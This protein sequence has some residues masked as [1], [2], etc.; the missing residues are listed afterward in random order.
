MILAGYV[1]FCLQFSVTECRAGVWRKSI[2]SSFSHCYM[3]KCRNVLFHNMH[4]GLESFS[5]FIRVWGKNVPCVLKKSA[6]A[7]YHYGFEC[8]RKVSLCL[9]WRRMHILL[10]AVLKWSLLWYRLFPIALRSWT[11]VNVLTTINA[12]RQL[13]EWLLNNSVYELPHWHISQQ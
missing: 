10:T 4:Q 13:I 8:G 9:L 1:L 6:G 7:K 5:F 11:C 3:A 12:L 2:I